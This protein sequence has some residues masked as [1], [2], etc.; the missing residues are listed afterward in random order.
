MQKITVRIIIQVEVYKNMN[1]SQ[2]E[3]LKEIVERLQ[4]I[5]YFHCGKL[6]VLWGKEHLF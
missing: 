6:Y 4:I 1:H 5:L 2:K 3:E